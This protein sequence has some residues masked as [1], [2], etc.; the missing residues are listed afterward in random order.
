MNMNRNYID[1]QLVRLITP[2]Q[3]DHTAS[4]SNIHRWNRGNNASN[5]QVHFSLLFLCCLHP[6]RNQNKHL[7]LLYLME[8]TNSNNVI[9]EQKPEYRDDGTISIGTGSRFFRIW[10]P[11]PIVNSMCND[12]PLVKTQ[13]PIITMKRPVTFTATP[14]IL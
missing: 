9:F 11:L 1:I 5:R 13:L 10:A 14:I 8:T 7:R 12:I 4:I 3:K 2:E 6:E